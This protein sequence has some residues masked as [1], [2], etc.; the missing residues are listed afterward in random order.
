MKVFPKKIQKST[1]VHHDADVDNNNKDDDVRG[2]QSLL[3][4]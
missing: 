1:S 2:K 4:H 3:L